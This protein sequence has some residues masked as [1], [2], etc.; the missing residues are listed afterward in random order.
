MKRVLLLICC[1]GILSLF[2]FGHN[3]W[4]SNNIPD[5]L[6]IKANAVIRTLTT[7]YERQSLEK[8]TQEVHVAITVLN[9]KG[10]S[11]AEL[12][13]LYDRNSNVEKIEGYLYNSSG[14]LSKKIRK[15]D[16]QDYAY[17]NSFTLFSDNRIKYLKPVSNSYPYTVEYSYKIN[18]D[19]VVG[20]SNWIP[21]LDFNI[22]VESAELIFK[23]TPE[24]DINFKELNHRFYFDTI[25][26]NDFIQYNWSASKLKAIHYESFS[27][28]YLAIFPIVLLSPNEIIYEG[29]SGDFSTWNNYGKWVFDLIK[30]QD[31]ISPETVNKIENMTDSIQSKSGKVEAVYKYMQSKTRY[32]NI[33]LGIG[34]FQPI[35][36]C[37]VD[38]KGYGDCKALSNYTKTLLQSIGINAYYTEIGSGRNRKLKF[39]EFPSANQTN[40]VIL[41]VPLEQDTIWLECTSQKL[42]FNYIGSSNSNRLA[43][44][45]TPDGGK[46]ARTPKYS[47]D[48]NI[49]SSK[50]DVK[51]QS[52]GNAFFETT[53]NFQSYLFEDVYALIHKSPK[54]QKDDLLKSLTS[55]GLTINT[56]ELADHS[57]TCALAS[58]KIKGNVA[59]YARQ[60]GTRLFIPVNYFLEDAYPNRISK[61]RKLPIS[62]SLGYQYMDIVNITVPSDSEIEHIPKDVELSSVF[63]SCKISYKK[64]DQHNI[65]ISRHIKINEGEFDKTRFEEINSFLNAVH[66]QQKQKIIAKKTTTPG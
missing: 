28:N 45:I 1:C 64:N 6:K 27:P 17:N 59:N 10:N 52:N 55:D 34:G 47:I 66:K 23:T 24:Y 61:S 46:L 14:E 50:I 4:D 41:C 43:L 60:S 22:A 3:K 20:F 63:G 56:Y 37:D 38:E 48:E 2:T 39:P 26:D 51:V 5:S 29:T 57:D 49:R 36:A 58:L 13:V 12:M 16:I 9:E 18:H 53:S 65:L 30:N 35:N 62:Q 40:H 44:I 42:P 15:K 54:E 25:T 19:G 32:V 31:E 11:A 8:Y 21:H 33:A 7:K